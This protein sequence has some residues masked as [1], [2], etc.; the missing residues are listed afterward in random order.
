MAAEISKFGRSWPNAGHNWS[1][2][3]E[4]GENLANLEQVL[5]SIGQDQIRV[6]SQ[7]PE[8]RLDN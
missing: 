5:G 6:E 1:E 7:F 4:F 3:A 2:L 8:Q